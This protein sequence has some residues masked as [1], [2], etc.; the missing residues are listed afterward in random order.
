VSGPDP[1][2]LAELGRDPQVV[3]VL[4]ATA[5][6]AL[7]RA[8]AIARGIPDGEAYARSLRADGTRLVS[9][10]PDAEAIEYGTADSTVHAPLRR[11][12]IAVGARV[13]DRG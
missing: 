12:A 8:R 1:D 5:A 4:E 6:E 11:A 10:H 9:T 3:A 13:V 7:V 2:W